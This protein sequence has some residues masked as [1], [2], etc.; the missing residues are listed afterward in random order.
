MSSE[1]IILGLMLIALTGWVLYLHE[2]FCNSHAWDI[3]STIWFEVRDKILK[4]KYAGCVYSIL[5]SWSPVIIRHREILPY[6]ERIKIRNCFPKGIRIEFQQV[7]YEGVRTTIYGR[8]D[9]IRYELPVIVAP[10][11]QFVFDKDGNGL[12]GELKP[13][14]SVVHRDSSI[15]KQ[16]V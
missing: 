9:L 6:K 13:E 7:N 5:T 10:A 14:E 1:T 16:K 4:D 12:G 2:H 3:D 8:G 15:R 11:E